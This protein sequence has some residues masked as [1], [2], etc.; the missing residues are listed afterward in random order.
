[1]YKIN[2]TIALN[3]SNVSSS[4][5]H[6]SAQKN[7]EYEKEVRQ[8]AQAKETPAQESIQD[9]PT[10]VESFRKYRVDLWDSISTGSAPSS[11]F[12]ALRSA[13]SARK[14]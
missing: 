14:N 9:L 11:L 6:A 12:T 1:M 3:E 4:E 5:A 7:M 2:K 13:W 10:V 8:A